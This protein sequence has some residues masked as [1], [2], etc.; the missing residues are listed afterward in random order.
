MPS[1]NLLDEKWI[2]VLWRDGHCGRVGI[3]EAL[4]RAKGIRCIAVASPIDLFAAHRF[5]L[6]LLYWKAEVVGGV[7]Q[8]RESL[9]KGDIPQLV[10]DSIEA[11]APRFGL[12]DDAAPFL[13]DPSARGGN[14]KSAGSFFAE[15]A[16]GTNI[17]FFHHGDDGEMRLCPCCATIGILRVIPWSQ[18]GGA[19][20]SP[21]IHNAP[22]IM[23][24]AQGEN[25]AVTLGLNLIPL[26][27]ESG[28]AKWSGHFKP[29][30][31]DNPIPFLEAFT[32]NPRRIHLLS[33]QEADVCWRC[34]QRGVVAVGPIVYSKNE[35]TKSNK[36]SAKNIPFAWQDPSAFYRADAPYTTLKSYDE[37]LACVGGDVASLIDQNSPPSSAVVTANADH[38]GW[39]LVIPC[40]NPANNKT[41]DHRQLELPDLSA[42]VIRS[43]LPADTPAIRMRGVD[44][45]TEPTSSMSK[46]GSARFVRAAAHLLTDADWA[47]LAAV[48]YCEMHASP[49]AFDV[50]S[51]LLWS[52]RGRTVA[53]LPSR[54]VAWLMLKLM[55]AVP[56]RARVAYANPVFCPL[57]S[58]PKR[59]IKE[60]RG[61]RSVLSPYPA[62]LPHGH[63]LE[64][65][66]RHALDRHLRQRAPAPIDWA[67]LC[68]RLDQLLD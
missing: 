37:K 24:M 26:Q 8:V 65:E 15:F 7:K 41:F 23:A 18:S 9:L 16:C 63:R 68:H 42:D 48:K 56:S 54:N 1:Y 52:L 66:L 45:W 38:H 47:S 17:A 55:A 46:G 4:E 57:R 2:P 44:G 58:L 61:D 28:D 12:L 64:T 6:T 11:E 13:Q 10:L 50:F 3:K 32:W 62:S 36:K 29:S 31:T 59:Q 53:G 30:D 22:P 43:A 40:T 20:L 27:G 14:R 5:L 34:G 21:S 19:G 49:A 39:R 51:G 33:P 35:N 67:G 25:L 60:R